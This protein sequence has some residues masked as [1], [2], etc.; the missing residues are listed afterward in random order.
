MLGNVEPA[1]LSGTSATCSSQG[2]FLRQ[3]HELYSRG[4]CVLRSEV[5]RVTGECWRVRADLIGL[6]RTR[7]AE[8]ASRGLKTLLLLTPTERVQPEGVYPFCWLGTIRA[9]DGP[10]LSMHRLALIRWPVSRQGRRWPWQ[11]RNSSAVLQCCS[12]A[13]LH[14]VSSWLVGT[15]TTPQTSTARPAWLQ[16]WL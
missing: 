1:T 12:A 9:H 14:A 10:M 16:D 15:S 2:Q 6:I 4:H 5:G 8:P 7:H 13:V 3:S 11:A